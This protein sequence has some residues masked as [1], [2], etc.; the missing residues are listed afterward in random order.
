MDEIVREVHSRDNL[1][2]HSN[3]AAPLATLRALC[4]YSTDNLRDVTA[5]HLLALGDIPYLDSGY[6][7]RIRHVTWF[8]GANA[9]E[10]VADN[11]ADYIPIFLGEIHK[12]I[13][14]GKVEFD[15]VLIHVSPP[16]EHGYCSLGLDVTLCHAAI[17]MGKKVLAQVNPQMPRTHG[18][19]FVHLKHI[20]KLVE[21]DDALPELHTSEPTEVHRQIGARVAGLI[22]DSDCLQMGI[23]AIPDAV[24]DALRDRRDLGIHTEMFSNMAVELMQLGVI[25]GE[26]KQTNPGKAVTSFVLGNRK[27]Y[28]FV[29]NNP[30]VEMRPVSYTNDPFVIARN[31]NMVAI[32]GCLQIDLTGQVVSD[33][34]G[35]QIV[36]GFGGQLDFIRGAARSSGGRPI[37]ATPSTA[38]SGKLS[39]IVA[40]HPM[41]YGVTTTRADVHWVATEHG[42]VDLFGLS[43]RERAKALIELAAPDFRASLFEEAGK[44]GLV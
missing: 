37:I 35:R 33:N 42:I 32:N 16:D 17:T 30:L 25:N 9:R 39:R 18:E 36:S 27:T 12:L 4:E 15:V 31:D 41:G 24:L 22:Q 34:T 28:D 14:S 19:S 20:D 29:N 1:Y 7:D 44:M 38:K 5:T 3:A 40:E 11:R 23:G 10:A 6:Q 2:V 13:L 26:H 43:R 21:V 8:V